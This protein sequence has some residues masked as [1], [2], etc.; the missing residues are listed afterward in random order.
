VNIRLVAGRGFWASPRRWVILVGALAV[1]L[2]V[3]AVV[4]L[5]RGPSARSGGEGTASAGA[6]VA[7]T[8]QGGQITGTV[9]GFPT[10]VGGVNLVAGKYRAADILDKPGG[11]VISAFLARI[12]VSPSA[13][14]LTAAVDHDQRL[15]IGV[16]D[17]PG[18]GA[19][20]LLDS[21]KGV[22]GADGWQSESVAGES[23]L[24]GTDTATKRPAYVGTTDGQLLYIVTSE[25][26]LAEAALTALR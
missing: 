11:E 15:S 1:V 26:S 25:R 16:W 19:S 5:T 21:W 13:A 14:T 17:V 12:G 6:A 22:A 7:T 4:I 9:P 23:V 18:S 24:V 20:E 8:G 2:V 3:L 10:S